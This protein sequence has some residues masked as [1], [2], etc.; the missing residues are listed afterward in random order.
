MTDKQMEEKKKEFR[1]LEVQ[2]HREM[3][4]NAKVTGVHDLDE[5]DEKKWQWIEKL[6]EEVEESLSQNSDFLLKATRDLEQKSCNHM[7]N[8]EYYDGTIQCTR[9]YKFLTGKE[10]I[11]VLNNCGIGN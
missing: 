6:I 11:K 10:Y 1:E 2:L 4:E 8:L 9:C 3:K 5:L 7:T